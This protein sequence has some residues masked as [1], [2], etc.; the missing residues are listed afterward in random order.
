MTEATTVQMPQAWKLDIDIYESRMLRSEYGDWI[1]IGDV[2]PL[3][4]EVNRL[5]AENARL[6]STDMAVAMTEMSLR[7][8]IVR[9][10]ARVAELEEAL[11]FYAWSHSWKSTSVYMCGHNSDSRAIIDGGAKARAAL[12]VK[13]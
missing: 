1:E 9:L 11:K 6:K 4:A 13:P 5:R 10:R 7:D 12:E 2:E 3:V 8:E